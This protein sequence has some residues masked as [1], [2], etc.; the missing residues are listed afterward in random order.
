MKKTTLTM[1]MMMFAVHLSADNSAFREIV[2][3]EVET[4]VAV[5]CIDAVVDTAP[6]MQQDAKQVRDLK[7]LEAHLAERMPEQFKKAEREFNENTRELLHEQ[8]EEEITQELIDM[9]VRHKAG[10]DV[11]MDAYKNIRKACINSF[12]SR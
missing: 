12:L 7:E 6:W 9:L 11:R 8:L 3:D 4:Y 1:I 2:E 5:P 10:A